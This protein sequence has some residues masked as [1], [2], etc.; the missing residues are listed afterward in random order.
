MD[1]G[2]EMSVITNSS[3]NLPSAA[4]ADQMN[5][6]QS[7]EGKTEQST[8][9]GDLTAPASIIGIDGSDRTSDNAETKRHESFHQP[10]HKN[11]ATDNTDAVFG[12][13]LCMEDAQYDVENAKQAPIFP[14]SHLG[15]P[16]AQQ[17]LSPFKPS[18]RAK[19]RPAWHPTVTAYPCCRP[20][21]KKLADG[22]T[23]SPSMLKYLQ[24][25]WQLFAMAWYQH[26]I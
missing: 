3:R 13:H 17:H 18:P 1:D 15:P 12:R 23:E 16:A 14:R 10:R 26:K 9:V 8:A 2:G 4:A 11:S 25:G 24:S 6:Q 19:P 21:V 7:D 5:T 22:L 20:T